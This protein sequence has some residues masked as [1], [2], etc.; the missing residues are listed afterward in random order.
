MDNN[1]YAGF[2]AY[3]PQT[4]EQPPKKRK[5]KTGVKILLFIVGAIGFGALAG[6][7]C[8]GVNYLGHT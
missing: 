4:D 1:Y 7:T 5:M 3:Q 2:N 8:Y 6:V